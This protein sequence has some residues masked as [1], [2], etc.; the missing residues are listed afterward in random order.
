MRVGVRLKPG[1]FRLKPG[2]FR[3]KPGFTCA[4]LVAAAATMSPTAMAQPA[5]EAP[6]VNPPA[7]LPLVPATSEAPLPVPE[8]A[9]ASSEQGDWHDL[10]PLAWGGFAIGGA[11]LVTGVITGI[12][13]LTR[14]SDLEER[15][16]TQC[17]ATEK[18]S[19]LPRAHLATASF[20][21][22]GLGIATGIAAILLDDNDDDS[23]ADVASAEVRPLI[24]PVIGLEGSF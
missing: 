19:N 8:S 20:V 17:Y 3:L 14:T 18:D 22:A 2:F 12:V 5:A 24:G 10:P 23:E 13:T 6:A 21:I 16:A 7:P 15:C 1:F 9:P 11:F 4:M